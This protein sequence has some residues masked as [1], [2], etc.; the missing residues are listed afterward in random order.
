LLLFW[1]I[2]AESRS[3]SFLGPRRFALNGGIGVAQD[4]LGVFCIVVGGPPLISKI[5]VLR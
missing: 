3:N 1:W 2:K 4:E 5:P